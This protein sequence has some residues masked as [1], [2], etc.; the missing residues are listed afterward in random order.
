MIHETKEFHFDLI[1]Y[2][3]AT[4][5]CTYMYSKYPSLGR[6]YFFGSAKNLYKIILS[7][8]NLNLLITC[9]LENTK[10]FENPYCLSRWNLT[11]SFGSFCGKVT[12]NYPKIILPWQF[13]ACTCT[14][15]SFF[16]CVLQAIQVSQIWQLLLLLCQWR[17]H[18]LCVQMFLE[19]C[20]Q[21]V[22]RRWW[23]V[24]P[25]VFFVP[26]LHS[27]IAIQELNILAGFCWI[28]FGSFM[29]FTK[30]FRKQS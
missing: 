6:Q 26:Y 12:F 22:S 19:L 24:R 13:V 27:S 11:P 2:W 25:Y 9:A 30:H 17:F 5:T 4:P 18:R 20:N 7:P 3:P 1:E 23:R 14:C 15:I 8:P 28:F 16:V 29:G 21:F 10:I